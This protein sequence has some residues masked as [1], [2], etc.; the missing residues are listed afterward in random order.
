[1]YVGLCRGC[2][3]TTVGQDATDE[4]EATCA[5][6]E[7]SEAQRYFHRHRRQPAPT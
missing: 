5:D 2:G 7:L 6:V 1:M 3:A 4:H